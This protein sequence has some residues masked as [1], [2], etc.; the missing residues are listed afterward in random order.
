MM[1][2]NDSVTG[3]SIHINIPKVTPEMIALAAEQTDK[4]LLI[5]CAPTQPPIVPDA[6]TCPKC[7]DGTLSLRADAW[8]YWPILGVARDNENYPELTLDNDNAWTQELDDH[9]IV[10]NS[11]DHEFSRYSLADALDTAGF[12]CE[13]CGRE[14]AEC[15]ADPC[16]DVI[17]DREEEQDEIVGVFENLLGRKLGPVIGV[18]TSANLKK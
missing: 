8:Q 18:G 3:V 10:C 2:Y 5:E 14:E 13:G 1:I 12:K 6:L 15:S 9:D 7:G 4:R 11:C 16:A 17:A